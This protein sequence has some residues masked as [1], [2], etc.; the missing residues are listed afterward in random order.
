VT[1]CKAVI[2]RNQAFGFS[3]EFLRQAH[4]RFYGS[5]IAYAA[6]KPNASNRL[7]S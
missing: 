2:G 1:L 6:G 3:Q 7:G 5:H 4:Q